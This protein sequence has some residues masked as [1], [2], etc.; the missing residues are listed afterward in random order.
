MR[1]KNGPQKMITFDQ[2]SIL[3]YGNDFF[4]AGQCPWTIAL[5]SRR[6]KGKV[7]PPKLKAEMSE[8]WNETK[9]QILRETPDAW[10]LKVFG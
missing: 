9:E 6:F 3:R 10:A 7:L 4:S 2:I 8:A 1:R 5:G